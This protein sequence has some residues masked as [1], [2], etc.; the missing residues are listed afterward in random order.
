M[1]TAD[2][3]QGLTWVGRPLE[4]V[5]ALDAVYLDQARVN[6]DAYVFTTLRYSQAAGGR[7]NPPGE[8]G[9]LYTSDDEA[10]AWEE[11]AARFR[12]Q[13]IA[14]LPSDMGILGVL[15]PVGRYVD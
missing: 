15:V 9:A 11:I 12:R 7:Y 5:R 8:F 3:V 10:T 14:A 6:F 1:T 4:L 13:G 2:G